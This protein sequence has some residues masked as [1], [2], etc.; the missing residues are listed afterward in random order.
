LNHND[1]VEIEINGK[2]TASIIWL[3]GLG[4]DGH[5]FE[6]IVPQLNIPENIGIRFLFPHA[7]I[8]PITINGGMPMRAWYDISSLDRQGTQD[9]KGIRESSLFLESLITREFNRGVNHRRIILAGFSQGGAIAL[10]TAL[11]FPHS[12]GGLLALSTWLP[13]ENSLK[14]E[15]INNKYSQSTEIPIFLAHGQFDPVIALKFGLES[16]KMLLDMKYSTLWKEYPMDHSVC[17]EEIKDIG[18][19]ISE[20]LS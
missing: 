14:E 11:R 2:P 9:E 6:S 16:K 7:P 1:I 5:D 8:R 17:V 10:H 3:H 4:A 19:W 15:V 18:L 12:L 13:L 20:A